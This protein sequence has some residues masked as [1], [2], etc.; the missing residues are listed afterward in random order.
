MCILRKYFILVKIFAI[1]YRK[2][3]YPLVQCKQFNYCVLPLFKLPFP[4][5]PFRSPGIAS[6][7]FHETTMKG[8]DDVTLMVNASSFDSADW[9]NEIHRFTW[10]LLKISRAY[11]DWKEI[12][13][14]SLLLSASNPPPLQPLCVCPPLISTKLRI[15]LV[16]K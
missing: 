1:T 16:R 7:H 14:P 5:P 6:F 12:N 10:D 13:L 4:T 8:K 9:Y 11:F 2:S 3:M 15:H